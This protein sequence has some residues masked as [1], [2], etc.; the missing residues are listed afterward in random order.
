MAA[1]ASR[2]RRSRTLF[3][4]T[5]NV[6]AAINEPKPANEFFVIRRGSPQWDAW[7]AHLR[8]TAPKSFTRGQLEM[9]DAWQF[10]SEWPPGAGPSTAQGARP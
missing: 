5:A 9:R 8:A 4:N 7:L 10:D 2:L 1:V 3:P 6:V